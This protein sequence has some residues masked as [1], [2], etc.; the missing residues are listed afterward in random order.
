LGV[1]GVPHPHA[2]ILSVALST[3]L[4]LITGLACGADLRDVE[5]DLV[6]AR[7]HLTSETYF[8]VEPEAL[9]A[10]LSDFT[11]FQQFTSAIVESRN[12]DPD[13]LGRPGFFARMEGCVLFY[14]KSFVRVGHVTLTPVEEI[15]AVANPEQSD[16][17]YSREVWTL[18]PE[19]EGTVMIYDFELEPAFWVPPVVGPLYIQSALRGGAERAVDRIEALAFSEQ[20]R[21]R[22]AQTAEA[23]PEQQPKT[24]LQK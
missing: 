14:C 11:L 4:L 6:D 24:T 18:V 7:Y 19:G 23:T 8:E 9:Y 1:D 12:I 13:D 5:V 17:Y 2:T 3:A 20:L 10:V 15:V 22:S 16:F 21:R